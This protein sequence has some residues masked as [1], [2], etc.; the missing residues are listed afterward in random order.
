MVT[1]MWFQIYHFM[2]KYED[3]VLI[4]FWFGRFDGILPPSLFR[5]IWMPYY[6]GEGSDP[7]NIF[8][9]MC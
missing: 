6:L 7:V 9:L 5:V 3:T 8:V 1:E 2:A 4:S